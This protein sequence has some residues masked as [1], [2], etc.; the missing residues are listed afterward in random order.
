MRSTAASRSCG[1]PSASWRGRELALRG[2]LD[3]LETRY[4]EGTDLAALDPEGTA[5]LNVNTPEE[6][7]RAERRLSSD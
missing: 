3:A 2:L 5:L 4:L 7:A 1:W 6:H